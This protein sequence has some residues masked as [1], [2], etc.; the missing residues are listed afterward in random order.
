MEKYFA[1]PCRKTGEKDIEGNV[2]AAIKM[3]ETCEKHNYYINVSFM[4]FATGMVLS[5]IAIVN[6]F[7]GYT[8]TWIAVCL[9]TFGIWIILTAFTS[10]YAVVMKDLGASLAAL[11]MLTFFIVVQVATIIYVRYKK[12]SLNSV[13]GSFFKYNV[14]LPVIV[15]I[16]IL[17]HVICWLFTVYFIE[18]CLSEMRKNTEYI[19]KHLEQTNDCKLLSVVILVCALVVFIVIHGIVM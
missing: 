9:L 1:K 6:F 19:P 14:T 12:L 11:L 17:I 3:P 2:R 10:C 7:G 15:S 13:F 18:D 5:T 8:Y 4:I 16:T